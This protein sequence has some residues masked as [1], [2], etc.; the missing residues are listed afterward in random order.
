[1]SDKDLV[2]VESVEES[3]TDQSQSTESQDSE[4]IQSS[5]TDEFQDSDYV[6]SLN[7]LAI[8]NS[9][10]Q[11]Q[12]RSDTRRNLEPLLSLETTDLTSTLP[13]NIN[14]NGANNSISE[15]PLTRSDL[16]NDLSK[17]QLPWTVAPKRGKQLAYQRNLSKSLTDLFYD[18][19]DF[20]LTT[21]METALVPTTTGLTRQENI[22][23][24]L[25]TQVPNYSGNITG[26]F[27]DW[28]VNLDS[29]FA[30]LVIT[31]QEKIVYLLQKM[32]KQAKVFLEDFIR[33]YEISSKIYANLCKALRDRFNSTESR[34]MYVREFNKCIN[35]PGESIYDYKDRLIELYAHVVP[36]ED[37]T[38][39]EPDPIK[40]D[41]LNQRHQ[42]TRDQA[43]RDTFIEGLS[44]A[45]KSRVQNNKTKS[46]E[47]FVKETNEIKISME[48]VS[49]PKIQYIDSTTEKMAAQQQFD[50]MTRI[51]QQVNVK[52]NILEEKLDKMSKAVENEQIASFN[53]RSSNF[54]APQQFAHFY[55]P[56]ERRPTTNYGQRNYNQAPIHRNTTVICNY[57][58]IYG[59]I[60]RDCR[61]KKFCN[62]CNSNTH[63]LEDCRSKNSN[64]NNVGYSRGNYNSG[65]KCENCGRNGHATINC[66][67]HNVP[68]IRRGQQQQTNQNPQSGYQNVTSG[69]IYQ[70]QN[71]AQATQ[72]K[73]SSND[74]GN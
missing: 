38:D 31:D 69:R 62:H 4:E 18:M 43:L 8:V 35:N 72:D 32:R 65:P 66:R 24:T 48:D 39:I 16:I 74:Q 34:G 42:R 11:R 63:S 64:G 52:F 53:V 71:Q 33:R 22:S 12:T 37:Y 17:A 49:Q 13:Q 46:F 10:D 45:L 55:N 20:Q 58:G 70:N 6:P 36:V 9:G 59:H 7:Q 3:I 54:N 27:D 47:D 25:I 23:V 67:I 40:R 5:S 50:L 14:N 56:N 26:R 21:G 28:L 30:G 41:V 2:Q 60:S 15:L 29:A 73:T 1:M 19:P 51:N 61:R 44:P 57:C 68:Y